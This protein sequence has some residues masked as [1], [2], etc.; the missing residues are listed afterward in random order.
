MASYKHLS[1]V[2][3]ACSMSGIW[4]IYNLAI[5]IPGVHIMSIN[6]ALDK[7]YTVP[8]S[9]LLVTQIILKQKSKNVRI[10]LVICIS[11]IPTPTQKL[12]SHSTVIGKK[13]I[14][15]YNMQTM[16]INAVRLCL[17]PV[18]KACFFSLVYNTCC[19]KYSFHNSFP[20]ITLPFFLTISFL[21][22]QQHEGI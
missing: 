21:Q 19:L 8:W 4:R 20:K 1:F 3:Q 16:W 12:S 13:S 7:Q 14:F 10:I 2:L 22:E 9:M 18:N 6:T 17:M 15:F 11:P 5:M